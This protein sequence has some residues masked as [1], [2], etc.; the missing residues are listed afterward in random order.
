VPRQQLR[1]TVAAGES[2]LDALVA[3]GVAC[4]ADCLRGE[5]GLCAVDVLDVQGRIDPRDMYM[6]PAEQR[7]NKRL[8]ACVSRV[9]GGGVVIDSALRPDA[10]QETHR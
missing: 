10:L 1:F 7:E 3:H 2:L 9:A 6:T 4:L 5:C 8:C